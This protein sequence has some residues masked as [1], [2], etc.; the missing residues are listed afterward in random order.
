MQHRITE[1]KASEI[2]A[3]RQ[4]MQRAAEIFREKHSAFRHAEEAAQGA[5]NVLRDT[6]AAYREALLAVC[7]NP[8]LSDDQRRFL[9]SRP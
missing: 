9:R 2:E 3:L 5:A 7:D 4:T 8:S 1:A 6:E